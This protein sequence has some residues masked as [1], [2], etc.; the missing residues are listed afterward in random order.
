[1]GFRHNLGSSPN[2]ARSESCGLC[3]DTEPEP[4]EP[5]FYPLISKHNKDTFLKEVLGAVQ[6]FLL[7]LW[8]FLFDDEIS[9]KISAKSFL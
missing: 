6:L 4:L 5:W 3:Q 1:M 7:Q 2:T 8:V 9:K